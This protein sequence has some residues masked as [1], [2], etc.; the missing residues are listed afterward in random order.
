MR[1][2]ASAARRVSLITV[3]VLLVSATPAWP[4]LAHGSDAPESVGPAALP[5]LGP[6]LASTDPGTTLLISQAGGMQ[7]NGD[8]EY[9]AVSADGG[10]PERV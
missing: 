10:G 8:N 7:G 9:P 6:R 5:P 4:A 1:N 2:H 3:A